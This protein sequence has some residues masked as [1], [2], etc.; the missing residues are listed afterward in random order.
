MAL[1]PQIVDALQSLSADLTAIK[2][3]VGMTAPA[4][5]KGSKPRSK[6]SVAA[7]MDNL[8]TAFDD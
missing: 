8:R 4:P 3:H 6:D 5:K 2:R 1:V 7:A